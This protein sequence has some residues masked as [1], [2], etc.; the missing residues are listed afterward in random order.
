MEKLCYSTLSKQYI[1]GFALE[2]E[3]ILR[4]GAQS[5]TLLSTLKDP[6]QLR[7]RQWEGKNWLKGF[8]VE[9]VVSKELNH[10]AAILHVY[11]GGLNFMK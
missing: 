9:L 7:R 4:L 6:M 1:L 2:L 3:K 5:V 10:F 8:K 11:A